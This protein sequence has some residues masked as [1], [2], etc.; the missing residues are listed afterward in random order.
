MKILNLY[1]LHYSQFLFQIEGTQEEAQELIKQMR[2]LAPK[3]KC[4]V[5][6]IN[7]DVRGL[8]KDGTG[9]GEANKFRPQS[10]D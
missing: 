10:G 2:A 9:D 6:I 4:F 8:V 5:Y 3:A 7:T 1:D